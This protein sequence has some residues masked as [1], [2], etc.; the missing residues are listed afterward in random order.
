MT[1]K[2]LHATHFI[3]TE[4]LYLRRLTEGD[5][6][7]LCTILKDEKAMYAYEHAFSDEEVK[8]W[9]DKQLLRY[10]IYGCGLWAVILKETGEFVGQCGLTVQPTDREKV[11]EIGYLFRRDCWN[12][13]YATEAAAACKRFAFEKLGAKEVYSIVRDTNL[14]SRRVAEKNGMTIKYSFVKHYY[15]KDMPHFAYSVTNSSETERA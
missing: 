10:Q 11:L 9:L 14:A 12:N 2:D 13:G 5:F 1:A 8:A 3:E 15:G 7:N 4:R 6:K